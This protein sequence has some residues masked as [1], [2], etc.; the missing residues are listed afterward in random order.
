M[1]QRERIS[2]LFHATRKVLLTIVRTKVTIAIP[3]YNAEPWLRE[4]LNSA[5]GQSLPATRL[6]WLMMAPMEPN[7]RCS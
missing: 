6:S 7:R 3:A 5:I 2:L 4:T 1:R